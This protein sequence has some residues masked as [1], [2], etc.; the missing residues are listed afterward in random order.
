M[1]H[2]ALGDHDQA[3]KCLADATDERDPWLVWFGTEPKLD[4]L[5]KDPRFI[6][7]F[8]ATRNPM[9]LK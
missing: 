8:P 4:P 6:E 2:L 7:L 5:R 1:A 9:A 3:L